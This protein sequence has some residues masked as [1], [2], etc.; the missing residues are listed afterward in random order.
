MT[1][2]FTVG[3]TLLVALF[4]LSVLVTSIYLLYYNEP[5]L[6]KPPPKFTR[7]INDEHFEFNTTTPIKDPST[8]A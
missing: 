1:A 5:G 6:K 4:V 7:V 2:I 8:S 3:V